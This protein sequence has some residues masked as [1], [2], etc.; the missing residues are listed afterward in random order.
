MC[1]DE[2]KVSKDKINVGIG[3]EFF[4]RKICHANKNLEKANNE[5]TKLPNQER[6]KTLWENEN[7]KYLK[8]L[9]SETF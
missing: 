3:K 8:I 9:K 1:M 6:M 5:R 4:P 7:Y 2:K